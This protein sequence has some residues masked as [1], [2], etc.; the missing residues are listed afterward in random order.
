MAYKSAVT[1]IITSLFMAG[2]I[3]SFVGNYSATNAAA[4]D[5]I[6]GWAWSSNIGWISFNSS[7][8]GSGG[9]SY[10]VY[11]DASGNLSGYAWSPNIGW[12]SFN[13]SASCPASS[14]NPNCQ[15][16]INL[17][18]REISGFAR[19]CA[20]VI[21]GSCSSSDSRTDGWD[22]WISLRGVNPDYGSTI[23]ASDP[24]YW[25]GWAWGGSV[26]GWISFGGV[27]SGGGSGGYG[28]YG[29]TSGGSYGPPPFVVAASASPN[30]V[31]INKS[32][33]WSALVSGG[34]APYTYTWSGSDGL[35]GGGVSISK[36]YTSI[37][38]KTG[39]VIVT[40]SSI[41]TRTATASFD[42]SVIPK[43]KIG[44]IQ[45]IQPE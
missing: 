32:V 38:V 21:G 23:S 13:H 31:E 41:P 1:F 29:P 43:R 34:N 9:G 4:G 18:T 11:A 17:I 44:G 40:D 3:L 10:G 2:V 36:V 5:N 35:S 14:G 45:E 27:L 6:F 39:T 19:A 16:K 15:P 33:N 12:I 22:G 7:N 20:G 8:S 24:H 25:N 42:V 37:G 30:P 26:V 28:V